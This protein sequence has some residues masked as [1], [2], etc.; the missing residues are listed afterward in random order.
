MKGQTLQIRVVGGM[1]Q[2]LPQDPVNANLIENWAV[3]RATL[4]LSSRVGYEKYRPDPADVWAPFGALGRID[5]LYVMQS[6]VSGAR[7]SILFESG[8]SLFLYYEVG[9]ANVLLN[10][11]GRAVPTATDTASVYAEYGDRVV[12]TNGYDAPIVVR[13]WPLPRSAEITASQLASLSRPVGWYGL[14]NQPDPLKVAIVNGSVTPVEST[15][16]FTGESTTNWYP[17]NPLALSFANIFGTGINRGSSPT[18]SADNAFEFRVSFISDTGSES[19]LSRPCEV[20]WE[21]PPGEGGYRYAPT[22]RIPLGPPGTVARR[23]YSS[24]NDESEFFFLA[25]CRNNIEEIFHCFRRSNTLSVPAPAAEDSSI[26]PAPR[27]RC[28]AIFKDC[29]FLDGGVDEGNRLF[30][31]KPSLI[32]QFGVADY[33]SLSSG[34]GSITGLYPY[35]NNL[36]IFRESAIDVLTGSYPTFSVQTVTRQVA[37][38]SPQTIDAVPGKGVF[39][40]ALDGVYCMKGGL[41]G[42]SVMEL[43]D[44]GAPLSDDLERLT[45]ECA[46]RAV[47]KYSPTEK[48]YHL[49]FPANGNDRP[50]LGVVYHLE[51]EGWSIRSGFP[52]GCIDR[53]HNGTLIFGH[54][55]GNPSNQN[56]EAGLFV[57]SSIRNMG[58]ALVQD[59]YT[60]GPP[61]VSIYESAW[62][63]FGDAQVKKQVQYLTLWIKTTGSVNL[64]IDDFKDFEYTPSGSDTRFVAQ[65]PDQTLQPVFGTAI[66]GTDQWQDTRL[67][68]IR[69]PIAQQSCSWFKFRLTTTDDLLLVGYELE[70]VARGT[71]V[72]AGRT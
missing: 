2:S 59:A 15:R 55:T 13:P 35:Y 60:P 47:G 6:S 44:V 53:L 45:Q 18:E 9:Q 19:P 10:L 16:D 21:I 40:L 57:L 24:L 32:D 29:L 26:F 30:F 12:I 27:A 61:P 52:V 3:D 7:Q 58:G 48:A 25:D 37:C 51:K 5:S 22:I 66:I 46:P 49:Y 23:I 50:N 42:G 28:C 36:I 69:V 4:G 17:S 1:E 34:G 43:E 68:C 14:P 64:L 67:V 62:H 71:N 20:S 56:L 39:F 54:H 63:D 72:I 38:R 31:S 8:G 11:R 65:P 70:Y 33:I 41:D